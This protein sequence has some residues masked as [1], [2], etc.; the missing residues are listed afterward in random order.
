M[1][2]DRKVQFGGW[3]IGPDEKPRRL[4]VD[5]EFL[6]KHLESWIEN[7]PTLLANDVRWVSRQLTLPDASRLDLL[8]LTKDGTWVVA[9]LKAGSVDTATVLQA[10]HYFLELADMTNADLVT[11]VLNRGLCDES[12]R[13]ELDELAEEVDD[14]Q[15]D[16]M[17]LVAGVG[18]G[19]RAEAAAGILTRHGFNVPVRVVTFQLL[20]DA[21]GRRILIREVE[22]DDRREGGERR[23]AWTLEDLLDRAERYGVRDEFEAIRSYLLDVGYRTNLKKTGLNFNPGKRLQAFWVTPRQGVIHMGYLS[24]NFP[25]L[26][27]I[28]ED[29]AVAL[30]GDNWVDLPPGQALLRMKTWIEKIQQRLAESSDGDD[31]SGSAGGDD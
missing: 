7:D 28:D 23:A 26:Y 19:E 20:R 9:E 3:G 29:E 17:L 21:D 8:G 31:A 15:R 18:T 1:P 22:D 30:L 24:S 14:T 10:L 11:R 4:D 5:R 6:E 25:A 16:F 12:L 2:P 13:P 27:G